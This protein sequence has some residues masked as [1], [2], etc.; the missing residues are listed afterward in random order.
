MKPDFISPLSW[1]ENDLLFAISFPGAAS[2]VSSCSVP[3]PRF[4]DLDAAKTTDRRFVIRR[5]YSVFT[6]CF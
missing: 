1:R 2:P 3:S 6:L 5:L 4:P